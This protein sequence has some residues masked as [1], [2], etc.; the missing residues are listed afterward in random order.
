M[1]PIT[2]PHS[3]QATRHASV[4]A[5][6]SSKLLPPQ[7]AQFNS[8]L[9][10]VLFPLCLMASQHGFGLIDE[11]RSLRDAAPKRCL[12]F[13]NFAGLLPLALSLLH[14]IPGVASTERA[15]YF[16]EAPNFNGR[17]AKQRL[18]DKLKDEVHSGVAHAT[19]S[20]TRAAGK[21]ISL[22]GWLA[23]AGYGCRCR[24]MVCIVRPSRRAASFPGPAPYLAATRSSPLGAGSVPR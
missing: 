22:R 8:I 6:P 13:L 9:I 4:C 3:A 19:L 23:R 1:V 21:S 12:I 7:A 5:S 14:V 11:P 10:V 17:F 24:L 18:P 15:K 20:L 2:W 16:R